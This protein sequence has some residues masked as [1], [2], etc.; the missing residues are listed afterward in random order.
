[1]EKIEVNVCRICRRK[2]KE[3]DELKRGVCRFCEERI[4]RKTLE[5]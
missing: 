2:L 1:M 4:L 5:L 3:Y